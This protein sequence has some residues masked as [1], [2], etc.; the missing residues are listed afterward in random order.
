MRFLVVCGPFV[1]LFSHAMDTSSQLSHV[2]IQIC[3]VSLETFS[4]N[5]KLLMASTSLQ[6][7]GLRHLPI[8]QEA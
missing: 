7:L 3:H 6:Y 8:N 1:S 4:S 5:T 2:D